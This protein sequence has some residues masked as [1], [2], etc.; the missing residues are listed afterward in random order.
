M[1][2]A[3]GEVPPSHGNAASGH[4]G[5]ALAKNSN[6]CA[7][8]T[9]AGLPNRRAGCGIS[10]PTLGNSSAIV[11]LWVNR[12]KTDQALAQKITARAHTCLRGRTLPPPAGQMYPAHGGDGV[13]SPG[14]CRC[15]LMTTPRRGHHLAAEECS[16]PSSPRG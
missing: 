6:Y 15:K 7:L 9:K 4:T 11:E 12:Y 3:R 5:A 14:F 2:C 10:R 16:Q 1:W 13:Y 8:E